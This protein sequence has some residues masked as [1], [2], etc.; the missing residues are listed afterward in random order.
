MLSIRAHRP[1]K[2]GNN[3]LSSSTTYLH[4]YAC[5]TNN[6]Q[7]ARKPKKKST[8]TIQNRGIKIN[9]TPMIIAIK[10]T[11]RHPNACFRWKNSYILTFC[12][13]SAATIPTKKYIS[14]AFFLST[15]LGTYCSSIRPSSCLSSSTIDSEKNKKMSR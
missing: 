12:L 14:T 10:N 8:G 5:L 3:I 13:E 1:A 4:S 7:I 6:I 2:I 15:L 11:T 9:I